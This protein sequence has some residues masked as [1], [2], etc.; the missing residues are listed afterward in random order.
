MKIWFTLLLILS[1]SRITLAQNL[2]PN[3]SFESKGIM[4]CGIF[5][6]GDFASSVDNWYSPTLGTPDAYSTAINQSC[7]NFQPNSSYPGP[8][9]LKGTQQPHSG[10]VFAGLFCYTIPGLNQ[11]EYIQ[12]ALLTPLNPG[13]YYCLEFY[14]SLADYTENYTDKLAVHFSDLAVSSNNDQQLAVIPQVVSTSFISDTAGWVLVSGIFQAT[15]AF[16]FITIGNFNDDASTPTIA[17]IGSSGNPGCYGAYY[18]IDDVSLTDCSTG[19]LSGEDNVYASVYPNPF[20]DIINITVNHHEISTI[21]I[22]DPTGRLLI[23]EN[24]S[25]SVNINT[26]KLIKGIYFYRISSGNF[27]IKKGMLT[28][29]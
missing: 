17:N 4:V 15:S 23:R 10:N 29:Q 1:F 3:P 28:K 21:S 9:G 12:S 25:Q 2:I 7:W 22:Y 18:F 11:R 27:Q 5:S 26:E 24:F 20:S 14:V 16:N 13:T 8:I 6:N 19:I